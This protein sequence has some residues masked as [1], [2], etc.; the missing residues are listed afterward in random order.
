M[1]A[2]SAEVEVGVENLWL[3]G[4]SNGRRHYPNFGQY[5]PQNTFKAFQ[6]AAPFCFCD[7]KYWYIEARDRPWDIFLPCLDAFNKKRRHLIKLRLLMMDESMSGWRPKTSKL[8]GLPNYTFEARKPVPLG[9]MFRNSVECVSGC[10]AFQDVVQLPEVQSQKKTF[11]EPSCLPGME[12][13]RATTAEVLRQVEGAGLEKGGW[14]GGDAWFGS[15][16]SSVEVYKRF[17]IHSTFVVKNNTA[18]F[19][20]KVLHRILT[21]RYKNRPAGHW[22]VMHTTISD[23]RIMVVAYAWSQRGVTYLVSTCGSTAVHPQKYETSFEDD[24][25]NVRVKEVNRPWVA[26]FLYEYLPLI[27]EHNKQRQ[28]LLNLERCWLTKNCW[29]RLLTT[30]V[31][32]SVVDMHRWYRN[33]KGTKTGD[34]NEIQIR[35]FSDLLCHRLEQNKRTQF[36]PRRRGRSWESSDQPRLIRIK[37]K[38]GFQT[39]VATKNQRGGGRTTGSAIVMNCYVCRKY[40]NRKGETVYRQTS[41]CC[42]VCLMPLCQESR[43]DAHAERHLTCFDEHRSTHDPVVACNGSYF[44]GKRFPADEQVEHHGGKRKRASSQGTIRRSQRKC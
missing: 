37:G 23:V 28:S 34:D 15:V 26:H 4:K 14:V 30:I 5:L 43:I 41:F 3:R 12:E 13:I 44:V 39:R 22:V 31:G 35:K 33:E 2:A 24:F 36:Q 10:L 25:G 18:Y 32:M 1:I 20:M 27:D 7:S 8:G 11:G 6:C 40:L 9:T 21:A 29:F 38:D 17:G 19:P 42:S 16:M